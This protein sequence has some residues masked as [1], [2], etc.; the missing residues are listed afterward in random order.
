[1][2]VPTVITPLTRQAT[3]QCTLVGALCAPDSA[4]AAYQPPSVPTDA[5]MRG[6][7]EV[8]PQLREYLENSWCANH[9]GGMQMTIMSMRLTTAEN[10]DTSMTVTLLLAVTLPPSMAGPTEYMNGEALTAV[11]AFAGA[12]C[13]EA[14]DGRAIQ[15]VTVDGFPLAFNIVPLPLT[16]RS[17]T[18]GTLHV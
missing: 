5:V 13:A 14:L 11:Q 15:R 3:L 2:A 12:L 7:R 18:M 10:D 1:M 8:V 16:A 4:A 6:V 17:G 9:T